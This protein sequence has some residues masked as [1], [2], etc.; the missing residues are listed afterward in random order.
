MR[1]GVRQTGLGA[2]SGRVTWF[3]P[4]ATP[5]AL[6]TSGMRAVVAAL[7]PLASPATTQ[8]TPRRPIAKVD[9]GSIVQLCNAGLSVYVMLGG[10]ERAGRDCSY[11]H[12]H[13]L[14]LTHVS[15][16]DHAQTHAQ[17][18]TVDERG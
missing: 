12:T 4:V 3:S 11:T 2:L 9:C 5:S 14:T 18:A 15:T 6:P 7:M 10:P 13:S 1:D 17:A 8:T 16:L